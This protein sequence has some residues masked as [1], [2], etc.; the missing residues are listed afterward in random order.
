VHKCTNTG[1]ANCLT[2]GVLHSRAQQRYRS[3]TTTQHHTVPYAQ[4]HKLCHSPGA[5]C[6]DPR[7]G[8][9]VLHVAADVSGGEHVLDV[10]A[11]QSWLNVSKVEQNRQAQ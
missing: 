3:R 8:P 4:R 7:L 1:D 10:H 11:L 5:H 6:E 9:R 2:L